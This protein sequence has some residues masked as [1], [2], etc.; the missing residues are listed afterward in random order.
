MAF[1]PLLLAL[2]LIKT[3]LLG[4]GIVTIGLAASFS[5]LLRLL[6]R[7]FHRD[8]NKKLQQLFATAIVA[9]LIAYLVLIVKLLLLQGW[10]DIPMFIASHIII[11]HVWCGLTAL[12]LAIITLSNFNLLRP[13]YE[14]NP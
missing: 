10:Q 6:S 13:S 12:L 9:H 3:S 4:L 7:R 2:I 8:V 14:A 5:V 1:L 11:H